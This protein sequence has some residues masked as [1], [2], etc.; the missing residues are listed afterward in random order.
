M[1][2]NIFLL[3]KRYKMHLCAKL[4]LYVL[5]SGFVPAKRKRKR[6]SPPGNRK[7]I[8]EHLFVEWSDKNKYG[9]DHYSG[10]TNFKGLWV[11]Q[12]T[13]ARHPDYLMSISHKTRPRPRGCPACAGKYLETLDKTHPELCKEWSEKNKRGPQHFTAGMKKKVWWD[14]FDCKKVYLKEIQKRTNP[15]NQASCTFCT[16][17][18]YEKIV[19]RI[20]EK[21]GVSFEIEER[22][23]K[24]G[25]RYDFFVNGCLVIEADGRPHFMFTPHFHKTRDKFLQRIE[26]DMDKNDYCLTNKL[27]LL[28]LPYTHILDYEY[29]IQK[30]L[31]D[32]P[33]STQPIHRFVNT[34]LYQKTYQL[35]YIN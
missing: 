7:P 21:L 11:C 25:S 29:Y 31:Q 3:L 13:N 5:F 32:I 15:K 4:L 14:C 33:H 9:L 34:D 26:D 2:T 27:H 19:L 22:E 10:G 30:M 1:F 16:M 8:P 35:A 20:L 18:S 28:R 23:L 17:S 12:N 24:E 6:C